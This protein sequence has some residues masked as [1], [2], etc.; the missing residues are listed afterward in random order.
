LITRSLTRPNKTAVLVTSGVLGLAVVCIA[1]RYER[2]EAV[3]PPHAGGL[4]VDP[5]G[6]IRVKAQAPQWG[7]LKVA[8]VQKAEGGWTDPVPG[9]VRID[10]RLASRVGAPLGGRVSGIFVDLGQRVV[11]GDPLFAISSPD[12]A[13]LRAQQDKARVDLEAARSVLDR[14][15]AM[16]AGHAVPAKEALAAESQEKQ[17]ELAARLAA[18]K[19]AALH[20][21][22]ASDGHAEVFVVPSPRDGIVV[23]KNVVMSQ[24]VAPGSGADPIVVA[25]LSSVVVVADLFEDEATEVPEGTVAQVS[26]ARVARDPVA[27]VVDRVSAVV[28]PSRHTVPVR[29]RVPNP[30]GI[31]RPNAYAT[32][33]FATAADPLAVQVPATAIVS[34]GARQ[35]VYV[36]GPG[37][38]FT[39]REVVVGAVRGGNTILLDGL[40][41]GETVLVEGGILLDNQVRLGGS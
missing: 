24:E 16:V 38:C 39:P 18:D 21:P 26:M 2:P 28:D 17:A 7:V 31:L 41:Q 29:V 19:L 12:V 27:G 37:E 30:D 1:L 15:Q 8:P 33:R 4:A 36:W 23:E 13:E 9:R 40:R 32:V 22:P 34:D 10:D 11:A 35:H 20:V 6:S 5:A 14:V 25:D 3:A